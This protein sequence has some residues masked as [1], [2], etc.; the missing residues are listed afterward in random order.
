MGKTKAK[1]KTKAKKY[2]SF[3]DF[4]RAK[5]IKVGRHGSGTFCI[6]SYRNNTFNTG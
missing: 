4:L 5:D 2:K 1:T 6:S 3:K